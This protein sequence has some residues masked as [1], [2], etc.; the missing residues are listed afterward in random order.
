M[1]FFNLFKKKEKIKI[2]EEINNDKEI[3]VIKNNNCCN[4]GGD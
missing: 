4:E 1:G 3:P 2:K